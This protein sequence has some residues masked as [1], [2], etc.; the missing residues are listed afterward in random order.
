MPHASCGRLPMVAQHLANTPS[1]PR[2]KREPLLRVRETTSYKLKNSS[3]WTAMTNGNGERERGK[4]KKEGLEFCLFLTMIFFQVGLDELCRLERKWFIAKNCTLFSLE[5]LPGQAEAK[6]SK[7]QQD[8]KWKWFNDAVTMHNARR[9]NKVPELY[10]WEALLLQVLG[11][12]QRL[13]P[14]AC[15]HVAWVNWIKLI[16]QKL[17][18]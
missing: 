1:T 13:V 12:Q 16:Y 18:L 14:Q 2:V 6:N 9:D 7:C 5:L 15:A 3:I 11:C 4:Q 8:V 17:P 10:C